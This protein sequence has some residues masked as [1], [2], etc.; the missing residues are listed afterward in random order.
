MLYGVG[1]NITDNQFLYID[2][3]ALIP[4]S[5]MQ[6]WTGSY[7]KLTKDKPTSSLFYFPVLLSVCT[8]GVI[9][10]AFQ[11]IFFLNVRGKPFFVPVDETDL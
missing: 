5:V 3:M 2:L 10:A 7:H 4:L 6:A 11:V 9:Q 1:G 8:A